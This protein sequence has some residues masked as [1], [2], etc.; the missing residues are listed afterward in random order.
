M[1]I[2]PTKTAKAVPDSG[3]IFEGQSSP[4]PGSPERNDFV[5]QLLDL[6]CGIK[7]M[8]AEERSSADAAVRK[9]FGA[10]KHYVAARGP[11]A[12]AEALARRVLASFNGRNART[13]ARQL[14]I[15]RS[16]V[17]RKIKQAGKL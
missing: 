1:S 5:C 7:P 15:G 14:G 6:V 17:Y 2:K 13:V 10:E 12:D 9:H 16:T 3:A 11:D 4:A 8:T